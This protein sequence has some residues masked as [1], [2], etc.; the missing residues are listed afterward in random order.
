MFKYIKMTRKHGGIIQEGCNKGRLKKGFFIQEKELKLDYLG[1]K[2][3]SI[4]RKEELC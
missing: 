2:K 1:L 4:Y 3:K